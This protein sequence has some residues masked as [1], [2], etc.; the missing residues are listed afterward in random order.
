MGGQSYTLTKTDKHAVAV[1][2]DMKTTPA[3]VS[4]GDAHSGFRD[5]HGIIPE[6][7][8]AL[9]DGAHM[10]GGLN[11]QDAYTGRIIPDIERGWNGQ[12][13]LG[14]GNADSDAGRRFL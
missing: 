7:C 12:V 8:G 13:R 3:I 2:D 5:E 14:D 9:S 10:G 1:F 6:V 11:G 4:N